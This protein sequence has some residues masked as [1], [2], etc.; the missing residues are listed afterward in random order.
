MPELQEVD[1]DRAAGGG[2]PDDPRFRDLIWRRVQEQGG[3]TRYGPIMMPTPRQVETLWWRCI[4]W[5]T[6]LETAERMTL[7]CKTV[8]AHQHNA[9]FRLGF[10]TMNEAHRW[11]CTRWVLAHRP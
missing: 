3:P 6:L 9:R 10:A 11:L 5:L 4:E 8:E 1:D 7:S 2:Y